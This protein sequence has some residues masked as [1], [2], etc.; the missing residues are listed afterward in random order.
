MSLARASAWL[1]GRRCKRQLA[2][3]IAVL[4]NRVE[5]LQNLQK[6]SLKALFEAHAV[7]N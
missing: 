3:F 2:K 1:F 6:P 5:Y 7:K 4:E